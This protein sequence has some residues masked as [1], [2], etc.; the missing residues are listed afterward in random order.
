V[1]SFSVARRSFG[2]LDLVQDYIRQAIAPPN[3]LQSHTTPPQALSIKP[4]ESS[5]QPEDALHFR[6]RPAPVI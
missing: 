5:E 4:Q 6:R 3:H 2:L 1:Q